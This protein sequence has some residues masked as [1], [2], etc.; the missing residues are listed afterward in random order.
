MPLRV[1]VARLRLYKVDR[2]AR[3]RV[4]DVEINLSI[5]RSGAKLVSVTENIDETPSGMLMHGIM[6]SIA[7]FY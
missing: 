6:S 2:L 7:E 1:S 5:Q 3:N 4:D